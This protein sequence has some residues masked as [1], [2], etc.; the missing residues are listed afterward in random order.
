MT[1]GLLDN[2][3]TPIW[4]IS[5]HDY[6]VAQYAVITTTAFSS[7]K[8]NICNQF[9]S[10][11]SI[12][13]FWLHRLEMLIFIYDSGKSAVSTWCVILPTSY[14]W[15]LMDFHVNSQLPLS[16]E[17]SVVG[18]AYKQCMLTSFQIIA[19]SSW[20]EVHRI[21]L[22]RL[23]Q[24][25]KLSSQTVFTDENRVTNYRL[26]RRLQHHGSMPSEQCKKVQ[27]SNFCGSWAQIFSISNATN[28][29]VLKL[30]YKQQ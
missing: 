4:I 20:K 7:R 14:F 5:R 21:R 28:L 30:L 27:F 13:M 6:N 3:Q 22:I 29:L 10:R 25:S 26:H 9:L 24:P 16:Q 12:V 19:A 2:W 11:C 23:S 15:I 17:R 8:W 1:R 18:P